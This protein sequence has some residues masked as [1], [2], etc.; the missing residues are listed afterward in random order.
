MPEA[1]EQAGL[2]HWS[3]FH[4]WRERMSGEEEVNVTLSGKWWGSSGRELAER[5]KVKHWPAGLSHS[6]SYL[7]ALGHAPTFIGQAGHPNLPN[8]RLTLRL[9]S[10][11]TK[12]PCWWAFQFKYWPLLHARHVIFVMSSATF[13]ILYLQKEDQPQIWTI[14]IQSVF[15][16]D[17]I[18]PTS[19]AGKKAPCMFIN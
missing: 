8:S 19:P 4:W 18:M 6:R 10:N 3:P 16:P 5:M 9:F 13:L 17:S 12:R 7:V 11:E 15:L 14:F 1:T 2:A